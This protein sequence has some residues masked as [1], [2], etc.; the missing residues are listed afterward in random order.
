MAWINY[1]DRQAVVPMAVAAC[2]LHELGH[3]GAIR[4]LGGNVKKVRLTAVG[5]EMMLGNSLGYWQEGAAALAGP[6]VNLL[7]AQ[8]CCRWGGGTLFAGINL[9]L[10]C[11]NLLPV[12]GL[13]G[14]R[15]L[16]C[17]LALLAGPDAARH[18]TACLGAAVTGLL[19]SFSLL[20]FG[21]KGNITLLLVTL[22]LAAMGNNFSGRENRTCH[23]NV[24]RVK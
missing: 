21:L 2:A 1:L 10:G 22:W 19:L 6:A 7:L 24:K 14:G 13:D 9:V 8:L 5:A 20:T 23:A 12:R 17:A 18:V 3:Y 15:A 16:Y 4:F 11:F